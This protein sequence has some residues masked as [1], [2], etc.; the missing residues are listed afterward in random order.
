MKPA[1]QVVA[2]PSLIGQSHQDGSQCQIRTREHL[3]EAEIK[4]LIKA[5]GPNH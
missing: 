4:K 3:T 2:Q 5:A 1:L